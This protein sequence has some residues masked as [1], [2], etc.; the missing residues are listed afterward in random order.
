MGRNSVEQI[1]TID[2]II[3]QKIR[4]KS[5]SQPFINTSND[6][7]EFFFKLFA[8]SAE[9][10]RKRLIRRTDAGL[11]AARGRVGGHPKGLSIAADLK[12]SY[13]KILYEEGKTQAAIMEQL[14]IKSTDRD[15]PPVASY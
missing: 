3:A 9:N 13:A 11:A 2:Y 14:G 8:L 4:F 10:E 1:Q 6:S 5:I 7:G 15:S 12:A